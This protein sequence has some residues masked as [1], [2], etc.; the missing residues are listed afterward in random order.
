[1]RLLD[2][3]VELLKPLVAELSWD[4][5]RNKVVL[6]DKIDAETILEPD[7][8]SKGNWVGAPA[9]EYDESNQRVL[10]Y[11]RHRDPQSRGFKG[12]LYTAEKGS[13]DFEE[14]AEIS[15]EQIQAVSIE[16]ADLRQEEGEYSLYLSSQDKKDSSWKV[17]EFRGESIEEVAEKGEKMGIESDDTHL[18]DPALDRDNLY[19]SSN[20]RSWLASGVRKINLDSGLKAEEIDVK[21]VKYARLTSTGIE[22]E[23][24]VDI[25]PSIFLTS[26]EKSSVGRLE[27]SGIKLGNILLASKYGSARYFEVLEIN[28]NSI[29]VFWEE[30]MK[31]G[32][33]CLK[34][35]VISKYKYKEIFLDDEPK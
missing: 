15:K 6:S 21:S 27:S 10:L 22:D 29:Y 31:Q 3:C 14:R 26:S 32:G 12:C 34:G 7:E 4:F 11:A 8:L 23:V 16:G 9:L 35:K 24:F 25:K 1:M 30:E 19:V 33:H 5:E 20:P 2:K 18:K 17:L 28:E 13:L